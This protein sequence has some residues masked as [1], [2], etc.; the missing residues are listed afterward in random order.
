MT[1]RFIPSKT[2]L[3]FV[4][5]KPRIRSVEVHDPHGFGVSSIEKVVSTD[6]SYKN[7][8]FCM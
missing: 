1:N 3:F 4:T 8:I 7:D 6:S 2:D 5:L